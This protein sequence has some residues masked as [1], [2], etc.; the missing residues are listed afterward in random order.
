M[1]WIERTFSL[2]NPKMALL[3]EPHKMERPPLK[4]LYLVKDPHCNVHSLS[5][6]RHSDARRESYV[7]LPT[8]IN[9][10]FSLSPVP[11]FFY[12]FF[13]FFSRP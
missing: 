11:V 13:H 8:D 7:L 2:E 4:K 12:Y 10:I 6:V 9:Y 1:E 3:E 5:V